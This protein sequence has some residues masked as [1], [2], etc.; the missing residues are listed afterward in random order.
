[1]S[2]SNVNLELPPN[3]SGLARLFPLP[4]LVLF[5]GVMQGLHIFEPRYRELM[6]DALAADQLIT[7]SLLKPK[8]ELY[9]EE[10]PPVYETV[11]VGKIVTHTE[12]DDGR[13]DLLLIGA[14]RAKIIREVHSGKPYRLAQVELVSEPEM[15]NLHHLITLRTELIE[16]F[17]DFAR[18]RNFLENESIQ[19][20]LEN[21]V[22]FGLLVDL[23][24]FSTGAGCHQLQ[25]I[26]ETTNLEAR[27]R[28]VLELLHSCLNQDRGSSGDFPP[29][30]SQN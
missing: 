19:Q 20:L 29:Q 26:L 2:F 7:M 23:V 5:P 25:K 12:T 16:T 14:R 18:A 9:D 13:F 17:R 3:F 22:P 6:K 21:E 15:D 10:Q 24:G 4:N 8:W 11:C 28:K 1:M 30:F 27:G